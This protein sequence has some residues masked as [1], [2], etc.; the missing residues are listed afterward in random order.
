MF[1]LYFS[2]KLPQRRHRTCIDASGTCARTATCCSGTWPNICSVRRSAI[3]TTKWQTWHSHRRSDQAGRLLPHQHRLPPG[4]HRREI[5]L[6][7]APGL[8]SPIAYFYCSKRYRIL[9]CC[10]HT[11]EEKF[12]YSCRSAIPVQKTSIPAASKPPGLSFYFPKP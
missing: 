9:L 1:S 3:P 7:K 8:W 11:F 5:T 6:P 12:Y 2:V 4:P 10:L